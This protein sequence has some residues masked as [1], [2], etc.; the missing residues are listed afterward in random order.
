MKVLFISNESGGF[1]EHVTLIEG[2]TIRQFCDEKL[3]GDPSEYQVR[4]NHETVTAEYELSDGD[5]VTATPRKT[6][7]GYSR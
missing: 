3:H 2:T 5:K 4:V 1:A 7:G 6:E